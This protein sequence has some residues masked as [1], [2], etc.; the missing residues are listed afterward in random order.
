MRRRKKKAFS[1]ESKK[2]KPALRVN[3]YIFFSDNDGVVL[4]SHGVV[5]LGK[6]LHKE[7]NENT[8]GGKNNKKRNTSKKR[9]KNNQEKKQSF[10]VVKGRKQVLF[11]LPLPPH[12]VKG[13]KTG[14]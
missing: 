8:P 6:W 2:K 10:C 12:T 1:S 3:L 11:S 5:I 9:K 4:L 14:V 7:G 13:R